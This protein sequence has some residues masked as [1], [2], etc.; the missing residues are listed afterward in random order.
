MKQLHGLLKQQIEGLD[1]GRV[2]APDGWRQL[3][4][5]VNAAYWQAERDRANL[6]ERLEQQERELRQ[7]RAELQAI[8]R[9]FPDLLARISP[10]GTILEYRAGVSFDP[11]DEPGPIVG[12]HVRDV[13]TEQVG[14]ALNEAIGL[15]QEQGSPVNVEYCTTGSGAERFC[16][17]RV[18]PL[19]NGELVAIVRDVTERR[20]AEEALRESEIRKCAILGSALDAI[21]DLD[22]DGRVTDLNPAAERMFGCESSELSAR[23]L[24]DLVFP[25]EARAMQRRQLAHY[26]ATG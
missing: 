24:A 9:A 14:E 1:S 5:R 20:Q 17:A 19:P 22:D 23:Y 7:T 2:A 16:E 26:F 15:V 10:D 11:L 25:P 3:V 8:V 18:V 12:R 13:L 4:E 21:M 6:R